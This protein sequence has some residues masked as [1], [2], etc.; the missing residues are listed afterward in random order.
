MPVFWS[1]RLDLVLLVGRTASHGVFWGI[2]ELFINL[3]S[4]SANGW[5]CV[6]VLLVVWHVQPWSLLVIE[7]SWVLL[8]RRRSLG[9]LLPIDIMCGQEVSGVPMS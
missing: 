3:G 5:S 9:E 1:I 4:L 8:F 6:P 7:W 2:C